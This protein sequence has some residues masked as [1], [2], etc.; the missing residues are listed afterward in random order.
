VSW[1]LSLVLYFAGFVR[2]DISPH[3]PSLRA[4][5]SSLLLVVLPTLLWP[6]RTNKPRKPNPPTSLPPLLVRTTAGQEMERLPS[7]IVVA[8]I[9][10][11]M[12]YYLPVHAFSSCW[13]SVSVYATIFAGAFYALTHHHAAPSTAEY[14]KLT[15][16]VFEA[17]RENSGQK[18]VRLL[19]K[20]LRFDGDRNVLKETNEDGHTALHVAA[21]L[22]HTESAETIIHFLKT[23]QKTMS[24]YLECEDA[25]KCTPL[26]LAIV[27]DHPDTAAVLVRLGCSSETKGP[28]ARNSVFWACL[29]GQSALV[30]LMRE[31]LGSKTFISLAREPDSLGYTS[32]HAACL[33]G[34]VDTL[35]VLLSE[36][37]ADF[38]SAA[39][40]GS[41]P[42]HTA[43]RRGEGAVIRLLALHGARLTACR[44]GCTP[45]HTA[46][47]HGR[48]DAVREFMRSYPIAALV[49]QDH[50]GLHPLHSTVQALGTAAANAAPVGSEQSDLVDSLLSCFRILVE[51]G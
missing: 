20:S 17:V 24:K 10:M 32:T 39:R 25:A 47:I 49:A 15:A 46:C 9:A 14:D 28:K 27:R 4:T 42:L 23:Q 38:A 2:K 16:K 1:K 48:V 18:L 29:T 34:S 26:M 41:T 45:L 37:A 22:G 21:E 35:N 36:Q 33:A 51:A 19:A 50:D 13:V 40:D 3:D 30:Q 11:S 6:L 12:V 43:A 31:Q 44:F 5:I 7:A 8:I